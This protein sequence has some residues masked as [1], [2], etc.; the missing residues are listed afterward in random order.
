M[1]LLKIFKFLRPYIGLILLCVCC[2][3][4]QAL[5]ELQIP[6]LQKDLS[7]AIGLELDGG[8][9]QVLLPWI[10]IRFGLYTVGL[11]SFGIMSMFLSSTIGTGFSRILRSKMFSK[12]QSMSVQDIEK[13]GTA[14]LITRTNNDIAQLQMIV[15]MTIRLGILAPLML[16]GGFAKAIGLQRNF[17]FV[18]AVAIPL[19]ALSMGTIAV[20]S[21]KMYMAVQKKLDGLAVVSRENLTGVRVVR[22]FNRQKFMTDKYV[23]A[24]TESRNASIKVARLLARLN[25]TNGFI[26]HM[27]TIGI[28][29]V[30]YLMFN[31]ATGDQA[32]LFENIGSTTAVVGYSSQILGS[33][34]GMANIF[35]MLPRGTASANRIMEV[36]GTINSVA[37]CSDPIPVPEKD[38]CELE[39]ENVSFSYTKDGKFVVDNLSFKANGGTTLAI[40]GSTGS[41][42]SS[43]V[44]LIPRFYDVSKG[45]ILLNG[46]DIKRFSQHDLRAQVG[47]VPQLSV[48]FS[49]SISDNIRYGKPE[50]T[51]EEVTDAARIA[52]AHDFVSNS[53]GGYDYVLSQGGKNLSGG[54][55]Q[56]LAIARAVV[57]RPKIYVFDDSFSALDFKT[58]SKLRKALKERT[59]ED[60]ALTI[61]VAQ[62]VS[63]VMDADQIIVLENG[64]ADAIGTHKELM[65][66][67]PLY[68]EIVLSQ[69]SE[70]EAN[71]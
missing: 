19:I 16:F 28:I 2:L 45:R 40:I 63:T 62:R 55:K 15:V 52:Q 71:Q 58:D 56:R 46:E 23:A 4:A 53:K 26:M 66:T 31:G 3:A 70:E 68:R 20:K 51:D 8:D 64:R 12:V 50:A 11:V 29:A 1:Q 44:N 59:V 37:E 36:L 30:A 38:L 5:L 35:M 49:G 61:I 48:L 6:E 27:T 14:S 9:G 22:A 43:I 57:K 60:K 25:P 33:I 41:G 32:A 34:I 10:W 24:N 17:A 39:F 13:F 47:F 65:E 18:Y 7:Y 67:C 54:Q 21:A 69:L 42:K